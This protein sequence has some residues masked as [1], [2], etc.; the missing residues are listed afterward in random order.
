MVNNI[1]GSGTLGRVT[2]PLA[3]RALPTSH[4]DQPGATAVHRLGAAG[5]RLLSPLRMVSSRIDVTVELVAVRAAEAVLA[6]LPALPT[7]RAILTGRV[8]EP[9][10][11]AEV[12]SLV[13][14]EVLQLPE[15]PSVQSRPHAQPRSDVVADAGEIFHRDAPGADAD[16]FGDDLFAHHVIFVTYAPSLLAGDLPQELPGALGAVGLEATTQGKIPVTIVPEFAAAP[17]PSR[18]C[19]SEIILSDVQPDDR[20]GWV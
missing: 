4:P 2:S 17:D 10:G 14:Y 12:S 7:P 9:A 13:G 18:V 8:A 19:S 5:E 1:S 20:A 11:N 16:R 6:P 3:G 15:C